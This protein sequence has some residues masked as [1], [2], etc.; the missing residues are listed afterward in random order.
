VKVVV[1]VPIG[2]LDFAS[3]FFHSGSPF[4]KFFLG[5]SIVKPRLCTP[6]VP[7]EIREVSS[8]VNFRRQQRLIYISISNLILAQ[9]LPSFSSHPR[10]MSE[11]HGEPELR[12]KYLK[13]R[14]KVLNVVGVARWEL[15]EKT[16]KLSEVV[17]ALLSPCPRS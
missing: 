12:I 11:L 8:Q 9:E 14:L 13:E 15:N 6:T 1:E 10:K 7:S 5:I 3:C 2:L 17:H 16:A 4:V